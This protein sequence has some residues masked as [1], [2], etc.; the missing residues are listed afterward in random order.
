MFHHAIHKHVVAKLALMKIIHKTIQREGDE[1]SQKLINDGF[2]YISAIMIKITTIFSDCMSLRH[3]LAS[4]VPT[5]KG[6]SYDEDHRR[7]NNNNNNN[8]KGGQ[9]TPHILHFS[10]N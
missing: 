3:H 5:H 7:P 8:T 2:M 4:Q 1:S 9:K 10:S 6:V